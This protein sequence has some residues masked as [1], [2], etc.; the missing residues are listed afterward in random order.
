M[1]FVETPFVDYVGLRVE[2][3]FD[4]VSQAGEA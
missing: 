2:V 4:D 1:P 3:E